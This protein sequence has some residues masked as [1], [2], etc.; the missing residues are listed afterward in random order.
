MAKP[1]SD[2]RPGLLGP[3]PD[4]VRV[5]I[6]VHPGSRGVSIRR[7]VARM[8]AGA[9]KSIAV[10]LAVAAAALVAFG[11]AASLMET[12]RSGHGRPSRL[13]AAYPPAAHCLSAPVALDPGNAGSAFARAV[14]CDRYAGRGP[15]V[16]YRF[17]GGALPALHSSGR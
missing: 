12:A 2:D 15:A 11:V 8:P 7:R 4:E 16:S 3:P 17:I 13:S 10:G 14:W 5:T 6:T 1:R 9:R